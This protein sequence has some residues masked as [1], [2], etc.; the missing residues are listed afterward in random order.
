M[1]VKKLL[2]TTLLAS[3]M[4]LAACGGGDGG[5]TPTEPTKPSEPTEPSGSTGPAPITE[6]YDATIWVS[7]VDGM[8]TLTAQ[9]VADFTYQTGI[10]FNLTVEKQSES[11]AATKMISDVSNGADIFCFAQ[12]QLMRLVQAGALSKVGAK[13]AQ[14][15]IAEN[16]TDSITAVTVGESLYGYPMTSDNGYFMYYDKSVISEDIV[17]DFEKVL[18][19][20]EDNDKFFSFE[21]DTSGWYLASWFFGAGCVSNWATDD[22]GDFTGVTDTFNSEKGLIAARGLANF[23]ASKAYN[24]SSDGGDFSK[25]SAALVSGTWAYNAVKEALGNNMGVAELPSFHVDGEAYHLGSFKGCKLMGVKP[26]TDPKKASALQKLA[27]YLTSEKG[28]LER[29]NAVAWGPSNKAAQQNEAVLANPALTAVRNQSPYATTQGQIHGSWWGL[30]TQLATSIK[31]AAG[32]VE[33]MAAALKTYEDAIQA[34]F[35]LDT[36]AWIFVGA[37]NGWDNADMTQKAEEVDEGIYEITVEIAADLDYKGGRFVHPGE[38]GNDMG[39]TIVDAESEA[40]I[41]VEASHGGDHNIVFLAGGV[42]KLTLN[43]NV[44][45][46]HIELVD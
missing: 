22:N 44:P 42:Y 15:L 43:V 45:S 20:C 29:F 28:Q 6:T 23:M 21:A 9:Q 40:L 26:Q 10:K 11:N 46:I 7:E 37:H 13:T 36:S 1:K 33:K 8:D 12:D 5:K 3:G 17:G 34:L 39:G 24:S 27:V 18:K 31:D 32:D 30:S 14:T 35:S 4:L 41:D 38:W 2:F 25:G 19:A 16:D